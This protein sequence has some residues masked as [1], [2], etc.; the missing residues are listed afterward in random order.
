VVLQARD[1]LLERTVAIKI[2]RLHPASSP[3]E[4][5]PFLNEARAI[6]RLSHQS[7]IRLF[8][9]G[10]WRDLP[11]LVMEYLEGS[12][13][14]SF[15]SRDMFSPGRAVEIL[16]HVLDG[17]EHA[18]RHGI[19]HRDLKPSNILSLGDRTIKIL[20][21]GLAH[22]AAA[23]GNAPLLAETGTP[24]YMA[25]EQWRGDAQDPRTD[26]WAVGVM[27]FEMLTGEHPFHARTRA[28]LRDAILG[29]APAPSVLQF[30]P[31]L[32]RQAGDLLARALQKEPGRRFQTAAEMRDALLE[33][34][35]LLNESRPGLRDG[36]RHAATR[37]WSSIPG[38]HRDRIR[39]HRADRARHPESDR[40]LLLFVQPTPGPASDAS[41]QLP[42]QILEHAGIDVDAL[43]VCPV[44]PSP[45]RH[46]IRAAEAELRQA[47]AAAG[48]ETFILVVTNDLGTLLVQEALRRD[49]EGAI[50]MERSLR[51]RTR[52]IVH[53]VAL[54]GGTV[55]PG[56]AEELHGFRAFHQEYETDLKVQGL[57]RPA[58]VCIAD[59]AAAAGED[60]AALAA[61][62]LDL[63][64][65][66]TQ[67]DLLLS[68]QT[69][70]HTYEIDHAA[71]IR[72]LIDGPAAPAAG[73]SVPSLDFAVAGS[74]KATHDQ[75]LRLLFARALHPRRVVVSG[76][77]GVGKST[78]L[79]MLVRT[80]AVRSLEE[81]RPDGLL[82]LLLP[83]QQEKLTPE[84]VQAVATGPTSTGRG[85]LLFHLLVERWCRRASIQAGRTLD[86]ELLL[87]RFKRLPTV[88][89]LDGVDELFGNNRGIGP[90]EFRDL[91]QFAAFEHA[92]NPDF[93]LVLG[94]RSSQPGVRTFASSTNHV[95]EV[96]RLNPAQLAERFPATA[97]L[98]RL[99]PDPR[100]RKLLLTPLVA[101]WL[102]PR[103]DRLA[104][105]SL[106]T[107]AQVVEQALQA[108]IEES[109]LSE[110]FADAGLLTDAQQWMDAL[111]LVAWLV[112]S[113]FRADVSVEE[114]RGEAVAVAGRWRAYAD[115]SGSPEARRLLYGFDLVAD[116]K[117]C[118]QLFARTVFLPA[119][120]SR[121]RFIHR[122]WQDFL[123]SRYLAR[124]V[125]TRNI[126][127][128]RHVGYGPHLHRT[129][130][131]LLAADDVSID[132]PMVQQVLALSRQP[133]TALIAGNFN[134]LLT[135]SR[136]AVSGEAIDLLLAK[137]GAMSPLGRCIALNGLGYR[138]L[139]NDDPSARDIRARLA[140]VF[141][142]YLTSGNAAEALLASIAWCYLQAYAR[143]FG[144]RP[145]PGDWPR[146]GDTLADRRAVLEMM[147][148]MTD[149]GP[150]LTVEHRSV[151]TAFLQVAQLA[152]ED[153][154]RP[155]SCVHYI[156]T[157]CVARL[158]GG[159]TIEVGRELPAVLDPATPEARALA[160]YALVPEASRLFEICQKLHD[161]I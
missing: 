114:L 10:I 22:I 115:Q 89:A 145:P 19:V 15:L 7:I 135:G 88:L 72:T 149:N 101:A 119:G 51:F 117:T 97:P 20:D 44:W 63:K 104:Q 53:L 111:M 159:H 154:D 32:P 94:V 42:E 156:Y 128:L 150:R 43:A 38:L 148:S 50:E 152:A 95:F 37:F 83:L 120:P 6:A 118:D 91:L 158:Y 2:I 24:A 73:E 40:V 56:V 81:C 105:R 48:E 130:G 141:H 138:G 3:Q 49:A 133:D 77:T 9:A 143:R 123:T 122:E 142:S 61:Q 127:E 11:Y 157:L 65:Y 34:E 93:S 4:A 116:E 21:F 8:D 28:E 82:A 14:Y 54:S 35:A 103:A 5:A 160:G 62:A 151:Q 134:A 161:A 110:A 55:A 86:A 113:R 58:Y 25:P 78:V 146:L 66:A 26:L 64:A 23:L 90:S 84:E 80:L 98:L 76:E 17:L 126:S 125:A 18:H 136:S 75:V 92:G 124:C 121:F 99:I 47:L 132:E 57:P 46:S 67:E 74:Q 79:R 33:V 131:E 85:R 27:L 108:I 45:D 36:R 12:P 96:L 31:A 155:I 16:V 147:C 68:W 112:F 100:A 30:S 69:I 144:T 140:P 52:R 109:H 39:Y 87:E 60:I 137:V 106:R 41:R 71:H 29:E 59:E 139:R 129:A 70:A 13:L 102:G 107:S 1:R 153:P